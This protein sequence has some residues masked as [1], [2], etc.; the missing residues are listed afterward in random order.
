M[1]LAFNQDGSR[2]FSAGGEGIIL[3]WDVISGEGVTVIDSNSGLTWALAYNAY[4]AGPKLAAIGGDGCIKVWQFDQADK[5]ELLTSFE[6]GAKSTT[7][8]F[9]NEGTRLFSGGEGGVVKVWD[10]ANNTL[11]A[12][13]TARMPYAGLN[14]EGINNL[15]EAQ[16]HN[17]LN[18]GA[19]ES[20]S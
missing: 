7:I 4:G 19:I 13:F 9:N 18:L 1:S 14:I 17:L 6:H 8:A 2:L 5:A 16:R 12:T 11:A 15:T 20:A 10:L 3:V